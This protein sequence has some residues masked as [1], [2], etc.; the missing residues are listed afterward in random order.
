[1]TGPLPET[2]TKRCGR[3]GEGKLLQAFSKNRAHDGGISNH[4]KECKRE[5]YL[6]NQH[7]IRSAQYR[8][9]YGI[10]LEEYGDLL[11]HQG[12]SCAVCGAEPLPHRKLDIDH[13][14]RTGAVRGLLCLHCNLAL[15]HLRESPALARA[16]AQYMEEL[17][18]GDKPNWETPDHE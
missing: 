3:C 13:D 11:E 15:G 10:D 7:Q 16:L 5:Y 6:T 18:G 2:E 1:M 4:C 14:H 17:G 9:L 8:R 12:G